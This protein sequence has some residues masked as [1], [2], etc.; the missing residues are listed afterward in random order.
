MS[1]NSVLFV[2]YD[3]P[4][5]GARG[6]K[7]SIKFI[8]YL[9]QND[10]ST[11]ILTVECSPTKCSEDKSL[12]A[13]L[14]PD[15]VVYR[16]RTLESLF[17]G[18]SAHSAPPQATAGAPKTTTA[19]APKRPSALRRMLLWAFRRV[20]KATR[21][22]D[23]RIL[24]LP[25]AVIMGYRAAKRH[26]CKVLYSSGPTHTNHMA[27]AMLSLL[28]GLPLVMDFRDAWVGNPAA[29]EL[30]LWIGGWNRLF[31]K[32]C[33][34][35]AKC[36][37]C[38]TD[39]IKADFEKRYPAIPNKY[40]TITNGFDR[41]D[42]SSDVV[43]GPAP[44][45]PV[46][47]MLHAGTLGEERSPREF[48]Q[49]LGEI[50]KENPALRAGVKAVFVG[51]NTPFNDG[52]TIEQYLDMFNC[53]DM[54]NIAGY[55]SRKESLDYMIQSN[56]LLLI[57]GRVPKEGAFVYGISGKLY[58]YAAAGKPVL[59]LSEPGSTAAV[60]ERLTLGPVVDLDNIDQIKTAILALWKSHK[61]EA[62]PYSPNLELLKSFE[63]SSLA[64]RLAESFNQVSKQG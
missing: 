17:H 27:G 34:R 16:A 54:V 47:T 29:P 5:E 46:M 51:K 50:A 37:V 12:F 3:F 15:L 33:I 28:T 48:L 25:F 9:P 42:F 62:I 18:N 57:I 59:T 1:K 6:T 58:D 24:W 39:G 4:P 44:K 19:T 55:V 13:E 38:T 40:V 52:H 53:R 14:P 63:F 20:G 32:T 56:V 64:G 36:V 61:A 60:A 22:P 49:A 10:W 8:R 31:E 35:I 43:L 26:Q 45:T 7:R 23:A 41:S 2:I 30:G 21:I 11:V